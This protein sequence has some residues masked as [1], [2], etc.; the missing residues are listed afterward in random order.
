MLDIKHFVEFNLVSP[1]RQLS[2]GNRDYLKATLSTTKQ[3]TE[4]NCFTILFDATSAICQSQ[5][6]LCDL[7][8]YYPCKRLNFSLTIVPPNHAYQKEYAYERV[9]F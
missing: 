7:N 2:M 1:L 8:T 5:L 9:I 3:L 4:S 6:Q